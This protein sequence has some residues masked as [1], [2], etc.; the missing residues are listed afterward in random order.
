MKKVTRVFI[1]I[2]TV[3]ILCF[4]FK[5]EDV[6]KKPPLN[7]EDTSIG[8]QE[9]LGTIK[10]EVFYDYEYDV[11]N[12]GERDVI[13]VRIGSDITSYSKMGVFVFSK[14]CSIFQTELDLHVSLGA[15][16]YM[17]AYEGKYYL[18]YYDNSVNMDSANCFYEIFS[19]SSSGEK[20]LLDSK[21][22]EISFEEIENLNKQEWIVYAKELNKYLKNAFLLVS[23]EGGK[24]AY[25][26]FENQ[27]RYEEKFEWLLFGER[28][29]T[30][31]IEEVLEQF[32]QEIKTEYK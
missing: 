7:T 11:T 5:Y 4:C 27:V 14:D 21:K 13:R 10:R 19:L 3:I 26:T 9:N 2:L 30:Y 24:L 28:E 17:V 31:V 25:S 32:I 6:D 23:T 1:G 15:S 18:M 22:V 12:D 8:S 16:Y 29:E 20:I